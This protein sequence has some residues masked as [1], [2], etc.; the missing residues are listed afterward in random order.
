M[1]KEQTKNFIFPNWKANFEI[2][3]RNVC[4]QQEPTSY[5]KSVYDLFSTE[6]C[7]YQ[8]TINNLVLDTF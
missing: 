2:N 7:T 6:T 4:V 8:L 5:P 3:G 1:F